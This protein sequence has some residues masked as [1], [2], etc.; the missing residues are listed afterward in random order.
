MNEC[1]GLLTIAIGLGLV[2]GLTPAH[3]STNQRPG[4]ATYS[5]GIRARI[6]GTKLRPARLVFNDRHL[7][8]DVRGHDSELFDYEGIRFQRTRSTAPSARQTIFDFDYWLSVSVAAPFFTLLGPY[9]LLGFVGAT[10]A[11][12]LHQWLKKRGGRQRLVLHS[13]DPHRCTHLALPRDKKQRLAILDEFARRF[14]KDLRTRP[15]SSLNRREQHPHPARGDRAPDFALF[16][17]DGV[18]WSL[19]NL[20]G[21]VILLNFWASWCE[22]CRRELPDLNQLHERYSDDGL[23]VLGVSDEDP[24]QSRQHLEMHGIGYPSLNDEDGN[25]MQSY[26]INAIPTSLV[27]GRDGKLQARMEGYTRAAAFEKALRPLLRPTAGD[28]GP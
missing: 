23:V 7:T 28:P 13:D 26:G 10:H 24:A 18:P 16:A 17:L 4:P 19:S 11:V 27:I 2:S 12:H 9:S 6:E 14:S 5:N 15:A 1:R 3:A 21:N 22:P 20:R 25:V 8:V